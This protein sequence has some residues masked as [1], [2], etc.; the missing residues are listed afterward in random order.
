[1]ALAALLTTGLLL[2]VMEDLSVGPLPPMHGFAAW[3]VPV[4]GAVELR[5][6]G[7]TLIH[8]GRR[9]QLRGEYRT[10]LTAAAVLVPCEEIADGGPSLLARMCDMTTSGVGFELSRSLPVGTR[11]SLTVQLPG[12]GEEPT[13]TRLEVEVR[14]CM[15]HAEDWRIGATIVDCQENDR[16]RV[17]A[18]CHVVWPY[19]RLRSE[20]DSTPSIAGL[21]RA[22][23]AHDAAWSGSA[24]N[25]ELVSLGL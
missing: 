3:F 4:L 10:P 2:R 17:L 15:A 13:P 14:S 16:R 7:R 22:D 21:S 25:P 1:M 9:R 19:M 11:A 23:A 18:Y 12:V 5:R 8:V 20:S 24:D 6:V